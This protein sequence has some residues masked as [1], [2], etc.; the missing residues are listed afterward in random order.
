MTDHNGVKVRKII[1]TDK[2]FQHGVL[3]PEF[4]GDIDQAFDHYS[5]LWM[6]DHLDAN[7]NLFDYIPEKDAEYIDEFTFKE[8]DHFFIGIPNSYAFEG[9]T[10]DYT[11]YFGCELDVY[12]FEKMYNSDGKEIPYFDDSV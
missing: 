1:Y 11:G 10:E 4:A 7:G 6:E 3:L 5:K 12:G 2:G 8:S 9:I